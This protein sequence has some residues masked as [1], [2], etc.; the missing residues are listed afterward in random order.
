MIILGLNYGHDGSACVVKDG[1]L[2][3]AISSERIT[4]VKKD[5]G[6]TDEVIDYVLDCAN[7]NINDIDEIALCDIFPHSIKNTLKIDYNGSKIDYFTG[8]LHDNKTIKTTTKIRNREIPSTLISHHIAHNASAFYTS[9]FEKSWCFSMDSSFQEAKNNSMIAFGDGNKLNFIECPGMTIGAGYAWFTEFLGLG[10]ALYKAG[11]TMGLASYG[12]S[13]IDIESFIENSF[14][15]PETPQEEYYHYYEQL[16]YYLNDN[17]I[18]NNPKVG[19]NIAGTIQ[20]IFEQAL[21]KCINSIDNNEID[22]LCL[23]GGSLLNCNANSLVK[24]ESKF[25]NIHHFPA[26]GDDGISVGCAL[27]LAHHIYNEPRHNYKPNELCFLG[28]D[29]KIEELDY[30]EI[31]KEISDGK[32][33]AWFMGKS[34]YGPRALGHRSILADPRN[35]HNR[36]L[37]NFIVKRREWF[38]PFGPSVLEEHTKEWFDFDGTSPY[39]LY[40][41]KV[42]KPNEIPAVTRVDGTSRIQTVNFD[43]NPHY[44]NLIKAFYEI[45][46]VPILLNTSLNGNGTPI[47]ETE[48]DAINFFKESNVDI[49]ILNGKILRK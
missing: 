38:R 14:F 49:L 21:L 47:L 2:I 5:D 27:Y 4:K 12:K 11:T 22:N 16:W 40:T 44:Y 32:I 36:E 19:M 48:E 3:S 1:K 34:E 26:C 43:D 39:M 41:A 37:I 42:L 6:L 24:N 13:N 31:A 28:K 35:Y 9:N 10:P 15:N 17:K 25:K 23:S 46:N 29:Y 20:K 33:V 30:N 7:I 18:L 45:T 8:K